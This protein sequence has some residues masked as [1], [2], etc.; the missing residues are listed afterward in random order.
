[1]QR[2]VYPDVRI[3]DITICQLYGLSPF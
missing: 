3:N 2:G 1:L